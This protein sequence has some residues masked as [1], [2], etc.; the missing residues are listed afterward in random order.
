MV[1]P[2]GRVFHWLSMFNLN[3]GKRDTMEI[4]NMQALLCALALIAVRDAYRRQ[5]PIVPEPYKFQPFDLQAL[6]QVY[7]AKDTSPS[8]PSDRQESYV[9]QSAS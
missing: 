4:E 3:L 2:L 9:A 8:R 7:R 1:I 5:E 6:R